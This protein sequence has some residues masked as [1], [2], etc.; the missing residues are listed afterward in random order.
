MLGSWQQ[1]ERARRRNLIV[2]TPRA[3]R[4]IFDSVIVKTGGK[5][6]FDVFSVFKTL[7]I[8]VSL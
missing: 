2:V 3:A 7:K 5:F 6:N 4:D 8:V 1:L